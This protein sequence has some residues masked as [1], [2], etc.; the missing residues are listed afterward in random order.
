MCFGSCSSLV[1]VLLARQSHCQYLA[2]VEPGGIRSKSCCLS[3]VRG[4]PAT[5]GGHTHGGKSTVMCFH[6]TSGVCATRCRLAGYFCRRDVSPA[7]AAAHMGHLFHYGRRQGSFIAHVPH[8]C[9]DARGLP[10]RIKASEHAH[11]RAC[12]V[13]ACIRRL[14]LRDTVDTCPGLDEPHARDRRPLGKCALV[15]LSVCSL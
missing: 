6:L 14:A 15:S 2:T 9:F 3:K 1:F 10:A 5:F 12:P 7:G 8:V 11:T 4:T 13:C